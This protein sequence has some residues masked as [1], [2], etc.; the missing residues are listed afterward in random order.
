[1]SVRFNKHVLGGAYD[2]VVVMSDLEPDDLLAFHIMADALRKAK[3]CVVVVGEGNVSKRGMCLALLKEI[4]VE[5]A[6]VIDGQTSDKDFPLPLR[7]A[8]AGHAVDTELDASPVVDAVQQLLL[9]TAVLDSASPLVICLKPPRELLTMPSAL[10]AKLTLVCYGSFN[11]RSLGAL[12]PD[13]QVLVNARFKE[14]LVYESFLVTGAENSLTDSNSRLF[15][16][17]LKTAQRNDASSTF[18]NG[19]LKAVRSWNKHIARDCLET[20]ETLAREMCTDLEQNDWPA[21][22][23][24]KIRLGDRN[25]KVVS[26][27]I[28][29]ESRQMVLAD[30]ALAAAL[31]TDVPVQ[32]RRGQQ[33]SFDANGYTQFTA[34]D[35]GRVGV[36]EPVP[37]A[38]MVNWVFDAC[39]FG[40][41]LS[42]QR[43][44]SKEV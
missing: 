8:F 28:D 39:Q 24:K 21:L 10:Q 32:V 16:F 44:R 14:T 1:M 31:C 27:I 26:N 23:A 30:C 20:I 43:T 19:L 34:K 33:L 4:G 18:W 13:W 15:E 37:F 7:R 38:T 2:L 17:A 12:K 3:K 22:R 42:V 9:E 35:G 41:L 25:W 6:T 36:F 29:A 5:Q 40:D 11:F